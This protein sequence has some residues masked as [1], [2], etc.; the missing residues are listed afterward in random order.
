M[1]LGDG[2][3]MESISNVCLANI[4][5]ERGWIW[6]YEVGGMQE[7]QASKANVIGKDGNG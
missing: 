4:A 6:N 2:L 5:D 7:A 3:V 1:L